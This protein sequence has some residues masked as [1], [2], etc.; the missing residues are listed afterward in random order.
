MIKC[1]AIG[2]ESKGIYYVQTSCAEEHNGNECDC[3]SLGEKLTK[4]QAEQLA[5]VKAKELNVPVVKWFSE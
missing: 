1:V 5:E 4:E 2:L 3:K